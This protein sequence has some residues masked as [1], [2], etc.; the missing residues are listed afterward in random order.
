MSSNRIEMIAICSEEEKP[1]LVEELSSF[2]CLRITPSYKSVFFT[3]SS[4][5]LFYKIHFK[6]KTASKLLL[7]LKNTILAS[8]S[9]SEIYSSVNS[10]QWKNIF[11]P[12]YTFTVE[13]VPADRNKK[14]LSSNQISKAVRTAMQDKFNTSLDKIPKVDLKDPNLKFVAWIQAKKFILSVD[15][16]GISLHKRGYRLTH[17]PCPIKETLACSVLKLLKYEGNSTLFDPF[18]GSGTFIIEAGYIAQNKYPLLYRKDSDFGFSYLKLF[19]K[20]LLKKIKQ[21]LKEESSS[22]SSSS[23]NSNSSYSIYGSDINQ[24]YLLDAQSNLNRSHL[25]LKNIHLSCL[26]FF[27]SKKPDTSGLLVSNLPYG[28]RLSSR[29]SLID[30]AFYKKIGDK[31]KKDYC[32]WKV[33]LLVAAD[34]PYKMIGLKPSKKYDFI[35]GGIKV[36][37]LVFEMYQ[38]SKKTHSSNQE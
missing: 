17:H 23:S 4:Y 3:V 25:Y 1:F 16:C 33:A 14:G 6:I 19:N 30:E 38:G 20:E 27:D 37:L 34:T 24:K 32:G 28:E 10:M 8:Q 29:Q 11:D 12:K 22:S 5:S 15:T 36:K 13:G 26:D 31:L 2:G 7:I 21:D 9:E 35:N 18:M